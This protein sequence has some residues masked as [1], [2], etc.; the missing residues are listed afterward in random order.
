[1]YRAAISLSEPIAFQVL[2][3][4]RRVTIRLAVPAD[5][6]RLRLFFRSLSPAARY[7]RF[8]SSIRE[9]PAGLVERIASGDGNGA[10]SLLAEGEAGGKK[11]VVG[12][13]CYV[14]ADVK[15]RAELALAVADEWQNDRLGSYLLRQLETWAAGFGISQLF[16]DTLGGNI[17]AQR[18]VHKAGFG[19][20]WLSDGLVRVEKDLTANSAY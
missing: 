12:E 1:M 13:A 20:T 15:I 6:E 2:R 4:H 16:G 18:L 11:L 10:V 19:L 7:N 8:M 14:A 3:S 9:A 5:R 17:A